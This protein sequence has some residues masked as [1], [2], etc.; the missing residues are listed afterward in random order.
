MTCHYCGEPD[1]HNLDD[2]KVCHY[3]FEHLK[4]V[5]AE[6]R[7]SFI[8]LRLQKLHDLLTLA[9]S[10]TPYIK[11]WITNVAARLAYLNGEVSD[12]PT[13]K[14]GGAALGVTVVKKSV[15]IKIKKFR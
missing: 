7:K 6:E 5:P 1:R 8:H 4:Y 9:P 14:A 15:A 3:C 11:G 10:P 13:P 2:T 12:D